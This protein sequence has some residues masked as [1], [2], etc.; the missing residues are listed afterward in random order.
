T[1]TFASPTT[2]TA[3]TQYAIVIAPTANLSAGTYAQTRSGTQTAGADVYSGGTRISST[4]SGSTWSIPF[5]GSATTDGGFRVYIA[6]GFPPS[7]T[8]VSSLKDANPK[9]GSTPNWTTLSWTA[10]TPAGTGVKFQV[11]GSNSQYGPFNF[12]GPDGTAGTYF[13]TSGASLSQFNGFRYL[14]YE[15]FLTTSSNSVTPTLSSVQVC[16]NDVAATS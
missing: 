10:T 8:F 9:T 14:K 16:F 5:T 7:G 1:A 12:V 4:T 13:T 11:A 2:V 6:G 3:G 15:A